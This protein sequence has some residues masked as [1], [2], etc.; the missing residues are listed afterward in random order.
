LLAFGAEDGRGHL[1][2]TTQLMTAMRNQRSFPIARR[3]VKS[4]KAAPMWGTGDGRFANDDRLTALKVGQLTIR[5]CW[6]VV[7]SLTLVTVG[8]KVVG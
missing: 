7:L 1:A 5:Q 2:P 6:R 8:I 3:M 4:P